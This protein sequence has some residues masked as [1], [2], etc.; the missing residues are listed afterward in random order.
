MIRWQDLDPE[1]IE[2]AV[3]MLIRELH[4]AAQGIDGAGGDDGRDIRWDSP[5]GLVIFEVKS[6]TDRLHPARRRQITA[7]LERAAVHNP[8]RWVLIMPLDPSPR[9]ERWFDS[10]RSR[11]PDIALEWRGRDWLDGQFGQHA[12]LRRYVEGPQYELL[13][14]AAEFGLEQTVLARGL[15]DVAARLRRLEQHADE[16]SP[17]WRMDMATT[18]TGTQV[19]TLSAR[20]PSAATLDPI[21]FRPVLSFPPDDQNATR[22]A[23]QLQ[24]AL[25]Y[26]GDVTISGQ[27]VERVEIEASDETRRLVGADRHDVGR[28]QMRSLESNEGLPLPCTVEVLEPH[29][30]VVGSLDVQ[31]ARRVHGQRGMTVSGT[32]QSGVLTVSQFI[33]Y[34]R[35]QQTLGT[36]RFNIASPVGR[37]PYAVRPVANF[38]LALAPG[39]R[40]L[41]RLGSVDVGYAEIDDAVDT[42]TLK[43]IA[44]TVMAFHELQRHFG[45]Q[46]PVPDGLTRGDLAELEMLVDLFAHGRARW[47][48]TWLRARIYADRV[49]EFLS[50]LDGNDGGAIV[51]EFESFSFVYGEHRFDI[52]PMRLYGPKMRLANRDELHATTDTEADPEAVWECFDD[53]SIYI[54]LIDESHEATA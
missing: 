5:E 49:G 29:G 38:L 12:Q 18:P 37:L 16:L 46:F 52:G 33:D 31:L 36:L 9:E 21:T 10:L 14:R 34:R 23:Q 54:T 2:R 32:D 19:F 35:E 41:L 13:E 48:D 17:F 27:Y 3:K 43:P 1:R 39:S 7:S 24:E 25:D 4:P 11:F 53:E 28:L 30:A 50:T 47:T 40:V 51:V 20:H 6:F 8:V 44:Q 15:P 26:G 42:E 22:S 45:K